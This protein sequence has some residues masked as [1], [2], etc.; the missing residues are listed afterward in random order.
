MATGEFFFLLSHLNGVKYGDDS[1]EF[2]AL[3]EIFNFN[4]DFINFTCALPPLNPKGNANDPSWRFL[5]RI[6]T[7]PMGIMCL[8]LASDY[9]DCCAAVLLGYIESVGRRSLFCYL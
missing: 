2:F 1:K 5:C 9:V 8:A 3:V 7:L 4:F 6:A